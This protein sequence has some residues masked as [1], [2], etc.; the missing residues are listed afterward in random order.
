MSQLFFNSPSLTPDF[1]SVY[2]T[3]LEHDRSEHGVS[4]EEEEFEDPQE[5]ENTDFQKQVDTVIEDMNKTPA[6]F[7]DS[8]RDSPPPPSQRPSSVPPTDDS[9]GSNPPSPTEE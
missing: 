9:A 5:D 4:G 7:Q 2:L 8:N 3:Y 1:S 6:S